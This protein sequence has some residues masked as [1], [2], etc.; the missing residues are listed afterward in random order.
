MYVCTN[1][2]NVVLPLLD[3]PEDKVGDVDL[4][5]LDVG[6]GRADDELLFLRRDLRH[7]VLGAGEDGGAHE[8]GRR[9]RQ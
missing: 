2:G 1:Q 6:V 3:V 7:L 8:P 9:Y 5:D 4:G